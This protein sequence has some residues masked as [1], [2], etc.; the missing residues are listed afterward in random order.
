MRPFD[1][2]GLFIAP[3]TGGGSIRRLTVRGAG[4]T[5]FAGGVTLI[6]QI[7]A[8]MVLARLLTP[9]DFGVVAMVT[10][11]SLLFVNFGFNGL[12]EAIVQRES[13]T[14]GLASTLFWISFGAGIL[15]TIGFGAS[16]FLLVELYHNPLIK[17]VAAGISLTIGATSFSTIHLAL[18]KRAMRFSAVSANEICA[19]FVSVGVSIVLGLLGWGYWAL[20]AGAI[21]QPLSIAVG[22]VFLCRW[23]PGFPRRVEGLSSALRFAL[24]TYGNFG[25]NYVSRNTDNLLVGWRFD[26]QALG[27]YKKAYDLFALTASQFVTSI[28]IVVV[29]GLSRVTKNQ[30]LYRIYL[31]NAIAMMAFVGMGLGAGLTVVGKDIIFVLLGPKWTLSG[32]IFTYF[33][34][35]IGFLILYC[36]NAWIHLSIG[37]PDRWFRWALVEM[38]VTCSL[39]AAGLHWGPAGIATAWSTSYLLLTL[40]AI[41]YAGRPINLGIS[42]VVSTVWKYILSFALSVTAAI[43][44]LSE[45]RSLVGMVGTTGALVRIAV[46]SVLILLLYLFAVLVLHRGLQPIYIFVDLLREMVNSS[47]RGVERMSFE[48]QDNASP[49][50]S[51]EA[52]LLRD[53][54]PLVSIL[55]PAYNAEEWIADT[56]RSAIGQTWPRKEIIVV[57]D[58]SKDA[59]LAIARQFENQGVRVVVQKNQGASTARNNAFSHSTGSYIQWLDA[60]DLLAPDKISRQM[61]LVLQGLSRRVL[62]SGPWA[63]FMYR[64]HRAHFNPSPLWCDLSPTEWILRKMELNIYMQTA[65]WLVSRE[66]TEA[67][68]PWDVR[69]LGDDDGEYFCRVILASEGVRFV[70]EAKIYYR[71]FRFDGLSYIDRF[72]DKIEAH[73]LS[74]QLHIKYLRSLDDSAAAREACLQ[75]LRDSLIYFYPDKKHIIQQADQLA[76]E[77]GQPLGVP[78]LSWKYVW[79]N[80]LFGWNV[81]K[82]TQNVLRRARW[83]MTRK[84]DRM[85]FRLGDRGHG[86]LPL[87][88]TQNDAVNGDLASLAVKESRPVQ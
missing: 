5:L 38:T 34:P 16:G 56:I 76:L 30:S 45:M 20:V 12:T 84:V 37:R 73:W 59:T 29:A 69:L 65:T 49:K 11:F 85:L 31:L 71:A 48:V 2:D 40:P 26:S 4:A 50:I 68:G 3:Q 88:Q 57:D 83:R 77:L 42:V 6:I 54:L 21:A 62:L 52:Q 74:M 35:G 60:D 36:T 14:R 64:P 66:L 41:W 27:Y 70:R 32:K 15:L 80:K 55:I 24:N 39:F 58:G 47:K 9:A 13:V 44:L 78:G 43:F 63:H 8:T 1:R 53:E 7:A 82:P 87:L 46:G 75:Y 51:P 25:V 22:A 81:V 28:A 18:L 10:T 86:L 72:P 61:E 67:A 79:L 33:G 17:P 19:R 23:M